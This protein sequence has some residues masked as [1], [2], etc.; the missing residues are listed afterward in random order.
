[1]GAAIRLRHTRRVPESSR[2]TKSAKNVAARDGLP[3][4][5]AALPIPIFVP[6]QACAP[7]TMASLS[8]P[9]PTTALIAQPIRQQNNQ[10]RH[11]NNQEKRVSPR[12]GIHQRKEVKCSEGSTRWKDRNLTEHERELYVRRLD[13]T[14]ST[15]ASRKQRYA[16]HGLRAP[17][18][19]RSH[20][21]YPDD[22]LKQIRTLLTLNSDTGVKYGQQPP[23]RANQL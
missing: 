21:G 7:K 8:L 23:Q 20:V 4:T 17:S 22:H 6:R 19:W 9:M 3:L 10:G 2:F 16:A 14:R 5:E 18:V 13:A 15:S 1:M 11:G 12:I